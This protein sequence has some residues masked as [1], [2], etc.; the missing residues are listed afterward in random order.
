M[1]GVAAML[2]DRRMLASPYKSMRESMSGT[3]P[4]LILPGDGLRPLGGSKTLQEAI[5]LLL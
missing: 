3:M 4:V 2:L 5:A 1:I